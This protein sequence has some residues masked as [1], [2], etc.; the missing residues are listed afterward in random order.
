[1]LPL[2]PTPPASGALPE[3]CRKVAGLIDSLLRQSVIKDGNTIYIAPT[4]SNPPTTAEVQA[5]ANALQ[6]V[7]ERLK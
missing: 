4:I 2:P 5:I 6:A 3:W 7:S 1:M